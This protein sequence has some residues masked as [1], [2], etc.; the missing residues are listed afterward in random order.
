VVKY[1][2]SLDLTF[3]A[4]ADPTRRAVLERLATGPAPLTELAAGHDITLAGMLKHVRV[5]EVANLI[6]TVKHGRT[7]IVEMKPQSFAAAARFVDGCRNRW[8]KRFDSL[9]E[10]LERE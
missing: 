7:R 4:L 3:R 6:R 9:T 8:N 2:Q 10:Y 1:S 5:L